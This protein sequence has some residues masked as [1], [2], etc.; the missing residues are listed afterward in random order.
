MKD[1]TIYTNK[2]TIQF[3]DVKFVS[4]E[5]SF[6]TIQG[7]NSVNKFPLRVVN[8]IKEINNDTKKSTRK[9]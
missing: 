2:E 9:K 3:E 5:K 4:V 8:R 1:V 6:V 7:E